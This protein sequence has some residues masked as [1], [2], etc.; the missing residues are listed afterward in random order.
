MIVELLKLDQSTKEVSQ[1]YLLNNSMLR[2]WRK[3][4]HLKLGDFSKRRNYLF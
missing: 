4:F 2:R 1:E 3:G